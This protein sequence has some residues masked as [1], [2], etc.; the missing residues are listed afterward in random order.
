MTVFTTPCTSVD[1]A[2][3]TDVTDGV[4]EAAAAGGEA[5][6]AEDE[7]GLD[8]DS[9][10]ALKPCPLGVIAPADAL[11]AE[12]EDAVSLLG[13]GIALPGSMKEEV[14]LA[15][16]AEEITLS[17]SRNIVLISA[18]PLGPTGAGSNGKIWRRAIA[19]MRSWV[20]RSYQGAAEK[21]R[22]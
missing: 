9:G 2:V 4:D 13:K 12:E 6:A 5:A 20:W 16:P 15:L 8:V 19:G 10:D 21:T 11:V 3:F 7:V 18:A 1:C 22:K 17:G 14:A